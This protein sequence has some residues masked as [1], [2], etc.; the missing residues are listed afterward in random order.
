M[1]VPR[2][3][4]SPISELHNKE[5]QSLPAVE[6]ELDSRLT[7]HGYP[8]PCHSLVTSTLTDDGSSATDSPKLIPHQREVQHA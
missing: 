3:V 2:A 1:H 4:C 7:H 8:A 5:V 6:L